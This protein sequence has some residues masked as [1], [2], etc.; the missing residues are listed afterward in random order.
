[1]EVH[2]KEAWKLEVAYFRMCIVAGDAAK[3]K[4]VMKYLLDKE[5]HRYGKDT[6]ASG[7][8]PAV[9]AT[10]DGR[11]EIPVYAIK[12]EVKSLSKERAKYYYDQLKKIGMEW[13]WD[14]RNYFRWDEPTT[15]RT[16]NSKY[17]PKPVHLGHYLPEIVNLLAPV[18]ADAANA[19]AMVVHSE[20]DIDA[21]NKA[22]PAP[23]PPAPRR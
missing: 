16:E 10:C 2:N 8:N 23:A 17:E 15:S 1:V 5:Q 22:K 13:E 3:D 20:Q 11:W 12:T 18:A 7:G 9:R 19:P 6:P 4:D 14:V 21:H